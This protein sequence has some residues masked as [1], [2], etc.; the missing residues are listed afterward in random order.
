MGRTLEDLGQA[1][2]ALSC[3][4]NVL[5][6]QPRNAHAIGQY[7]ALVSDEPNPAVLESAGGALV[8][9]DATDEGK[10]LVGYGLPNWK[11]SLRV[12][13]LADDTYVERPNSAYL[14]GHFYGSP[15]AVMLRADYGVTSR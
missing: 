15:R 4:L 11:L 14:Y 9:P 7:L 13:N 3:Y 6:R 12:R 10:A 5:A 1:D 2:G 8:N